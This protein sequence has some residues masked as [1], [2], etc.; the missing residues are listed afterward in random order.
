MPLLLSEYRFGRGILRL[1]RI[2][3]EH[4]LKGKFWVGAKF[5]SFAKLL[6]SLNASKEREEI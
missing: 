4:Q 3:L 1:S 2:T 5:A 6:M